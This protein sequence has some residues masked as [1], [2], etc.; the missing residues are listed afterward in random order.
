MVEKKELEFA[1]KDN[2]IPKLT[3]RNYLEKYMFTDLN[4]VFLCDLSHLL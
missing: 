4:E 3:L 1:Q 2:K